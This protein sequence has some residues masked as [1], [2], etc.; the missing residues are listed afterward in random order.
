[1]I[2][3]LRDTAPHTFPVP[4]AVSVGCGSGEKELAL[5]REGL[6]SHFDL[7][8]VSA[9]ALAGGSSLAAQ[10]GISDRVRFVHGSDYR[11]DLDSGYDMVYWDN[12]LHHMFD[13]WAAVQ[14]S[15]DVLRPG[16]W[17]VMADFVGANRFQ[18]SDEA[19]AVADLVR[20]SLP[21]SCFANPMQPG[22]SYSR[23]AHRPTLQEMEY[24][25]SEA[26]DSEAI[27]PA[28]EAVFPD[29]IIRHVG[30]TVYH[31]AISD[32]LTNIPEDSILPEYLI[33]LDRNTSH[34][35]HYAAAI[36]RKP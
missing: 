23:T 31:L 36:A 28:I 25:P 16:G 7:F 4:R 5:V 29:P 3:L 2:E 9:V 26:A 21:D 11:R 14:W 15:H 33:N 34:I 22:A 1:M 30:G 6:V 17:F 32:V 10:W 27:I 12:A 18:W 35:P 8:D 19:M 20:S 24:D 13:A